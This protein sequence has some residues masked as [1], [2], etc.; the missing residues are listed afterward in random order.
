MK[1]VVEVTKT[2]LEEAK[3]ELVEQTK[4]MSDEDLAFCS[5]ALGLGGWP[6]AG[7]EGIVGLVALGASIAAVAC[8]YRGK[9]SKNP[10]LVKTSLAGAV[11]GVLG[12]VNY[13]MW[14]VCS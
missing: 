4:M 3:K 13:V 12:V 6:L 1:E 8:A 11:F 5:V 7:Q 14:N 9:N 10:T 2:K